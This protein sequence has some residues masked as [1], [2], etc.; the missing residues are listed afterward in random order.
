MMRGATI[1][2]ALAMTATMALAQEGAASGR[3][4]GPPA[5]PAWEFAAT[6]Y[7]NAP[8]GGD[9]Y[10]SGIFAADRGALHLEARVNYE[11]LHARSAFVGWTFS[12]GDAVK[13]EATPIAGGVTGAVR[14]P[15]AGLE[16][17]L[18]A[19]RIDGYLEA[20]HVHARG[21]AAAS[22]TYAWSEAGFRPA[23]WLRLGAVAQRTRVWGGDRELQRGPF[24]QLTHARL[25]LSGYWF[26]PGS[27][28]QVA[29]VALGVAF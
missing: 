25:T 27:S 2:G 10:A 29:I 23:E 26:N 28:A 13:L 12:W 24:V 8:R 6:G 4:A 9:S 22:Y 21:D 17:A 19:G 14:G 3:R 16:A 7:W 18:S 5:A 20:E 11:A 15:I 1:A